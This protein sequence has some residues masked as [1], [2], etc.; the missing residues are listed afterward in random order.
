MRGKPLSEISAA[1]QLDKAAAMPDMNLPEGSDMGTTYFLKD[2]NLH[3]TFRPD[4]NDFHAMVVSKAEFIP[5]TFSAE[6]RSKQ[7]NA[8][9]SE[10]VNAHTPLATTT[11]K[12]PN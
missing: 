12:K 3:L 9:W 8:G 11:P 4:P 5:S 6:E 10:W 2:G 1:Y 7:A